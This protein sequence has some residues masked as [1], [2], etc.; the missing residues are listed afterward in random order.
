VVFSLCLRPLIPDALTPLSVIRSGD[1]DRE[2]KFP[3]L[4]RFNRSAHLRRAASRLLLVVRRILLGGG[5]GEAS[6]GRTQV[7]WCRGSSISMAYSAYW[8]AALAPELSRES[9]LLVSVVVQLSAVFTGGR[10]GLLLFVARS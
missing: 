10:V 1:G 4:L 8:A 5:V 3:E 2:A 9:E 7:R 6:P